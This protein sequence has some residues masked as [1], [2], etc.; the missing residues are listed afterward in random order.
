MSVN[1]IL[2]N[3]FNV[4]FIIYILLA[5]CSNPK[6]EG[7]ID[8]CPPD[9]NQDTLIQLSSLLKEYNLVPLE[10]KSE[11]LISQVSKVV[12]RDDRL[13]ISSE[14]KDLFVFGK[15]GKFIM[16]V[17]IRGQGPEEYQ[18]VYDFDINNSCNSIYILDFKMIHVYSLED[19]TYLRSIPLSVVANKFKIINDKSIILHTSPEKEA[20]TIIDHNGS[21]LKSFLPSSQ[22]NWLIT[23]IPFA[24]NPKGNI[25]FQQGPTNDIVIYD[26][27]K[28]DCKHAIFTKGKKTISADDFEIMNQKYDFGAYERL[29]EFE[30]I[31]A[32]KFLEDYIM[33]VY[34]YQT[35]GFF[36]IYNKN[37]SECCTYGLT[38]NKPLYD[39]ICFVSPAYLRTCVR[40]E[41]DDNSIITY[42]NA[43]DFRKGIN[44]VNSPDIN[45]KNTA[46]KE[47]Y[48]R[49]FESL[50]D[51][52]NPV[53]AELFF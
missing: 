17:G 4:L 42:V 47:K 48:L 36:S 19:G 39:D 1:K 12:R 13:Y 45:T 7:L 34:S 20:L 40:G 18:G 6:D 46:N 51:S 14:E 22:C 2:R 16:K 41:S 24:V 27:N 53:I 49:V 35:E 52:S 11:C 37:D 3:Q 15:T 8:L 32:V 29:V 44:N 21:V 30:V 10:T 25:I 31:S 33:T 23:S 9:R 26:I 50:D 38:L 43:S 28:G 5:S